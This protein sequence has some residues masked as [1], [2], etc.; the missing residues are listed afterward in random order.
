MMSAIAPP[1]QRVWPSAVARGSGSSS[2]SFKAMILGSLAFAAGVLGL[3][4]AEPSMQAAIVAGATFPVAIL[5]TAR[6]ADLRLRI[7]ATLIATGSL[8]F[9]TARIAT[10]AWPV[11]IDEPAVVPA[12]ASPGGSGSADRAAPDAGSPGR[13]AID[14]GIVHPHD[15]AVT[16]LPGALAVTWRL[17]EASGAPMECTAVGAIGVRVT[18]T[19]R[20]EGQAESAIFRCHAN[21]GSLPLLPG[22]YDISF[23]L[24]GPSVG[25]LIAT[26]GDQ[27]TTITAGHEIRL[28]PVIFQIER[29]SN[30][31]FSI[32]ATSTTANCKAKTMG[33]AGIDTMSITL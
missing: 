8:A 30:L 21:S 4:R 28:F 9:G 20:G 16:V 14:S 32:A 11:V 2:G 17:T 1:D 25:K 7:A 13:A 19:P 5:I 27:G 3:W 31:A 15:S 24:F 22:T 10:L 18:A 33:G 29:R 26:A 12:P 23:Q 6:V